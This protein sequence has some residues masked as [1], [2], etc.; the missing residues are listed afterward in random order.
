M[1]SIFLLSLSIVLGL[2]S[3]AQVDSL[4]TANPHF[5]IDK[6][7]SNVVLKLGGGYFIPKGELNEFFGPAPMFE[8]ACEFPINKRKKFE[9]AAQFII[10]D[11][12]EDFLYVRTIDTVQAKSTFMINLMGRFKKDL[13][14]TVPSRLTLSLGVGTSVIT[15]NARNPFYSGEEGQKKYEYIS[16]LL[17]QPGLSFEHRFSKEIRLLIGVDLQYAPYKIEGAVREEIGAIALI[18]KLLLSF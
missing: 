11:Q 1:K 6:P 4:A 15:T 8:L 2:K 13:I 3:F 7:F 5:A 12:R 17:L 9:A 16:T 18:P 14:A 10:P